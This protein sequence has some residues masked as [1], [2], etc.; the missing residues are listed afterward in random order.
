MFPELVR[1][2]LFAFRD[3]KLGT[4]RSWHGDADSGERRARRF[5]I[6]RPQ[7]ALLARSSEWLGADGLPRRALGELD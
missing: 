3:P 4:R 5:A 1:A 2:T 7:R 6:E